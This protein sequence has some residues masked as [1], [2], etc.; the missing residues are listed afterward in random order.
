MSDDIILFW[1][2]CLGVLAGLAISVRR[3]RS[4][5]RGWAVVLTLIL[6][7]NLAGGLWRQGSLIYAALAM[8]LLLVL[9]PAL[10]AKLFQQR[11]LQQR[12]GAAHR[13]ARIIS[14]L[15]PADGWREQPKILHAICLAEAGQL[16]P[17]LEMLKRYQTNKSWTG[18]WAVAALCRVTGRWEDMIAWE[19]ERTKELERASEFVPY[20]LRARGETGDVAGLIELY[21]RRR[22]QIATL[23][24]PALRDLCR[25]ML[26]SFTGKRDLV[27]Q[28]LSASS[29]TVMPMPTQRFWLATADLFAGERALA[30]EQLESLRENADPLTRRAIERRLAQALNPPPTFYASSEAMIESAV[31]EHSHEERFGANPTLFST[32]ARMTQVLILLNVIMFGVEMFFRASEDPYGLYRLGALFPPAVR[33]GEWWRLGTSLFLH[34]GYLHLVLNMI[35]LWILGPFVEFAVGSR[36]FVVVY[37]L[38]GIGSMAF[39]MAFASGPAGERLTVGASGS[40]MGLVGGTGALMLRGWLKEKATV[41][42]KRLL[43]MIAFVAMQ[44]AMDALIPNVSM[45]AHLAGAAIGFVVTML[46]GNQFERAR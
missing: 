7:L 16:D 3:I 18:L 45:A 44:T 42:R 17:A 14:W 38:A 8:W 36:K 41:A 23:A 40:V 6:L 13:I 43:V 5:G 19:A 27:E 12:Y 39:V 29:L 10:L 2:I 25:L 9:L 21:S 37:L 33:G 11:V 1:M 32:R 46:I 15:H 28:L 22:N 26:F 4:G 31:L 34:F 35:G 20:L 24:A 30:R